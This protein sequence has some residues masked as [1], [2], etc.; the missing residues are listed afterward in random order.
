MDS[1][2]W[3]VLEDTEYT[4][5]NFDSNSVILVQSFFAA[6][7]YHVFRVV[8]VRLILDDLLWIYGWFAV[9]INKNTWK[10]NASLH[11]SYAVISKIFLFSLHWII[12]ILMTP[13]LFCFVGNI[14]YIFCT[15]EYTVKKEIKLKKSLLRLYLMILRTTK[16][17]V[18]SITNHQ[19][20]SCFLVHG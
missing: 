1:K 13:S 11:M 20:G 18:K 16:S 3:S 6:F 7:T 5:V 12:I 8:V 15:A 9:E 19:P 2:I 17:C 14:M 4:L 10:R